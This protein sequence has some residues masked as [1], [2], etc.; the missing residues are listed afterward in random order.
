MDSSNNQANNEEGAPASPRDSQGKKRKGRGSTT[1]P[2]ITKNKSV[3][4]RIVVQYDEQGR[5]VGKD[6]PKF[7]S[8]LGVL[9]RTMVPV[10]HKDWHHVPDDLKD[11]L[12]ESVQTAFDVDRNSK[13]QV[14]SSISV[15]WRTF[16]QTLTKHMCKYKSDPE[17]IS[18][19]PG[20]YSFLEQNHWDS[21][22]KK[23]N[24]KEF[25][26][27]SKVQ[28]ESRSANKCNHRLSRKSYAKFEVELKQ[29]KDL[30][31]S[32]KPTSD[33]SS[34]PNSGTRTK[35][36]AKKFDRSIMWKKARQNKNGEYDD[37]EI[38]KQAAKID[39]ITRQ[40]ED[41]SLSVEGANDIL[42]LALGT[43]EHSG[44]LRA[45]GGFVT[46]SAYFHVPRR[47]IHSRCEERQQNLEATVSDLKVQVDALKQGLP[48]TPHSDYAGSNTFENDNMGSPQLHPSPMVNK[49]VTDDNMALFDP[50]T[51]ENRVITEDNMPSSPGPRQ[52]VKKSK[53]CKL[54][55]GSREHIVAHGTMFE[56]VGPHETIHTVLLGPDNVRVSVDVVIVEDALLPIPIPGEAATIGETLG[57]QLAWPKKLVLVDY[58][59]NLGIVGSKGNLGIAGSKGASKNREEVGNEATSKNVACEKNLESIRSF[60]SLVKHLLP[61]KAIEMKVEND[62]FGVDV[63]Y[64]LQKVDMGYICELTELSIQCI[65]LYMSYLYEVMKA[66]NMHRSF[67]FVNPYVTSVKNKPGDD[68]HEALLARRLEDAKS[69]ELVFAPCNIGAHWVLLVI[70]ESTS[71]VYYLDS[72]NSK[73]PLNI[74][75]LISTAFIIYE[76]NKGN[77][78]RTL[79]W[80]VVQCPKQLTYVE[81][82]FYVMM[83]MRDLIKDQG[84]LSKNNFNGRN[85]FT[86]A[87]I[88]EVRVEWINFVM[89][90]YEQQ[91]F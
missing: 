23:R 86:K 51:M 9:A 29:A 3:G 60:T 68:S 64:H 34:A 50:I 27:T 91:F 52:K 11:K 30:V 44:R 37:E 20:I 53:Q 8:Y 75:I 65:V 54:A 66:S 25:E 71:T 87:E 46:P 78:R 85:T 36:K 7:V 72:I 83:F 31:S 43:R 90:K 28:R 12:W 1:L 84:I 76:G 5:P 2:E 74:K 13:K 19:P 16:K 6:Q 62:L 79:H 63:D 45:V 39:E 81:C 15:K 70:E 17:L 59:G 73:V 26:A 47:G 22:V 14:L 88:D 80:K 82:G 38:E 42:T 10:I 49:V 18:K 41:G 48:N 57:Y 69:G 56:R 58:E 67:F 24:C 77:R 35:S 32:A 61:L 21:F 40:V 33:P 4:I 55:V 89:T